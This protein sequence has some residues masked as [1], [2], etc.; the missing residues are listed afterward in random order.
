MHITSVCVVVVLLLFS[1]LI[2]V[3]IRKLLAGQGVGRSPVLH[4]R[5]SES[6]GDSERGSLW[7]EE[8]GRWR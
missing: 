2:V 3:A 4:Q 7:K 1:N 8:R 6:C 5:Q